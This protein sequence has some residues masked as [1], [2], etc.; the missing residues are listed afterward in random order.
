MENIEF[1]NH[2]KN[3][4]SQPEGTSGVRLPDVTPKALADNNQVSSSIDIPF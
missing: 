1:I 4:L 2:V 3:L